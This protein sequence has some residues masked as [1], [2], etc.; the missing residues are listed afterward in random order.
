[1]KKIETKKAGKGLLAILFVSIFML[2]VTSVFAQNANYSGTWSFNESKSKLPEMGFRRAATKIIVAQD[3][4]VLNAER[5]S[6]GRD[7]EERITKEK[8]TLDGKECENVA[9]MDRT[10][11]SVA[12]W[13]ADGKVLTIKSSMIFDRNGESRETKSSEVWSL[14]DD[15]NTLTVESTM[16]GRDGEMKSTLVY[17]KAK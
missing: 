12:T 13:S 8:F 15:K 1:M 3:N 14:S 9:F 16:D 11:K 17:D 2:S 7:G 10:R 5:V 6:Q 4:L